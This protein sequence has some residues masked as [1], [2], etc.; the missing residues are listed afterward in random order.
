MYSP[1]KISII[2]LSFSFTPIVSHRASL[3]I[4]RNFNP[5]SHLTSC[6]SISL[7]PIPS[8]IVNPKISL[9]TSHQVKPSNSLNDDRD[10]VTI[11]P[12]KSPI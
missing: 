3:V 10:T 12:V 8:S 1:N 6:P 11:A 9:V 5:R 2:C 4:R 7:S